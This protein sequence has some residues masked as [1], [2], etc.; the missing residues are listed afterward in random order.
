MEIFLYLDDGTIIRLFWAIIA[1]H[2]KIIGQLRENITH[3]R[4][5]ILLE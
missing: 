2:G 1:E 3:L 5:I 4:A